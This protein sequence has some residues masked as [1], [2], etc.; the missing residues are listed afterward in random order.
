MTESE[1]VIQYKLDHRRGPLPTGVDLAGLFRWF[2]QCR[3]RGLIG[4]TRSRYDGLAY[5]NISVR[6]PQGFVI[7]GTQTGGNARL[8]AE[9]L[10]WVTEFDADANRL[11]AQGP[12]APSSEAMTHGQIYRASPASNAVIHVHS[13]LI[14]RH[15]DTLGL[16]QTAAAATYGTPAMA[17]EVDRLLRAAADRSVGIFAMGGHEDGIIAYGTDLDQAGD[18]LLA[19]LAAAQSVA[20][21]DA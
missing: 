9:D 16:A 21:R 2:V 1:G 19:I 11:T 8:T 3:E 6:A 10:A 14:W 5:G 15:A 4:R 13:P 20:N 12:T 17:A 7:S 18:L